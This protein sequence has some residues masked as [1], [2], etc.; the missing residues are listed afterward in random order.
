MQTLLT[1]FQRIVCKNAALTQRLVSLEAQILTK[2]SHAEYTREKLADLERSCVSCAAQGAS[3]DVERAENLEKAHRRKR[4]TELE[5]ARLRELGL[6]EVAHLDDAVQRAEEALAGAQVLRPV[7][8]QKSQKTNRW[9]FGIF[10][11]VV[12]FL[13]RRCYREVKIKAY[14]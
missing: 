14:T 5:V 3:R 4:A 11:K 9:F 12:N 10:G 2:K 1:D 8:L 6:L 13:I 7:G